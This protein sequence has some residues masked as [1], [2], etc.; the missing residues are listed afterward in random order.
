M[1]AMNGGAAEK[2]FRP[3]WTLNLKYFLNYSKYKKENKIN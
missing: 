2:N 3:L 1:E